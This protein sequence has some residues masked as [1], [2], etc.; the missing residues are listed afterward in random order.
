MTALGPPGA[1]PIVNRYVRSCIGARGVIR[2]AGAGVL[3][4]GLLPL[5]AGTH[6]A[7]AVTRPHLRGRIAIDGDTRDFEADEA[8]FGLNSQVSPPLLEESDIDSRWQD[9]DISQIHLTWDADSI[10]IAADG[11]INSNNMIILVDVGNPNPGVSSE[12]GVAFDGLSEMNQLNSWRRNFTFENGF[13]PDFFV[14]TWDGNKTPRLLSARA[15]NNVVDEVPASGPDAQATG[16]FRSAATFQGTQAGRSLEFSAPWWKVL[17]FTSP[18]AAERRYVP[19]L[20]DTLTVLPEGVRR[21]RLAGVITAGGD[22]T[23][24]P[25]SA[26]DNLQGHETDSGVQVTIDNYAIVDVDALNNVSG[27]SGP[28]GLPDFNVSVKDRTTFLVQPPVLSIRFTFEQLVFDRPAFAPD[29]GEQV[30]WTFDVSPKLD[31]AQAALRFAAFTAAIFDMSGKRVRSLYRAD[32]RATNDI[33]SELDRWDGRDDDGQ[34]VPGGIYLLRLVLEPNQVRLI[35][36]LAV[37]R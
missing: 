3:L 7:E 18:T 4:C 35:K 21:I 33:V 23:G 16:Q 5:V 1:Y 10:Y 8:L 17:G 6:P 14:A 9:N 37:V 12:T 13:R 22:G 28:D 27:A 29:R 15:A 36:P 20:G 32:R 11:V 31:P 30:A 2:A 34:I 25:D 26:P 24:G 19:S